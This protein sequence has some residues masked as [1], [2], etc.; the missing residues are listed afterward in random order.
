MTGKLLDD[1]GGAF[2]NKYSFE[3]H[4]DG[5]ALIQQ[6]IIVGKAKADQSKGR[7]DQNKAR[8]DQN[9]A[10]AG[11]S[12]QSSLDQS[13]PDTILKPVPLYILWP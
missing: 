6:E 13:C 1:P 5:F 8:A 9:K 4:S 11:H 3:I 2:V 10:R 12:G 7:A